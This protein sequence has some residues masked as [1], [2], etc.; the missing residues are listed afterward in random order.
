MHG[1]KYTKG[2]V[3]FIAKKYDTRIAF[4]RGAS[5]AYR[6]AIVLGVLDEICAHMKSS[7]G[8][9]TKKTAH[10]A[11]LKHNSRWEF[12]KKDKGAYLFAFNNGLLDE[13]CSHMISLAKDPW[14]KETVAQEALKHE[15]RTAF[16]TAN[17]GAYKAAIR[18]GILQEVTAH[19]P[20]LKN[21][22]Y[23]N[24][25]G[26][27]HTNE[28]LKEK[29]E[30]CEYRIEFKTKFKKEYSVA[31]YRKNLDMICEN[32]PV[33]G[34]TSDA[35]RFLLEVIRKEYPKA[36]SL[37]DRKAKVDGKPHIHGFDID[38]YVPELRKGV[39]FD[40]E[41]WHSI[42]GLK[43]TRENWPIEDIENYHQ[44][45]DSYFLSKGIEIF[46]VDE[47][48]WLKN[49]EECIEKIFTFLGK[50]HKAA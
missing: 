46:H 6:A 28:S 7:R 15:T 43:R 8:K 18:L 29:A 31:V 37:K 39:E 12:Q 33:V 25:P 47:K 26:F 5:G 21:M 13:I 48:D 45:K 44:I 50:D 23:D 49:K 24:H 2:N 42:E 4:K 1:I 40:G 16:K 32:I 11:A 38:V 30:T 10:E 34:G 3:A 14:T 20:K 9:W 27:I 17:Q 35:E 19:M 36:Q 41:Y 22:S